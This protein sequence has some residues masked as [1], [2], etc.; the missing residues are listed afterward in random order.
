LAAPAPQGEVIVPE[1]YRA[2]AIDH[3]CE[4]LMLGGQLRDICADE[5]MPSMRVVTR[6]LNA[7][8]GFKKRFLEA[9][10][11]RVLVE[12]GN[13]LAIADGT[14]GGQVLLREVEAIDGTVVRHYDAADTARDKLR[15]DTR[16]KLLAKLEPAVF[17]DK[18]THGHEVTGELAVMLHAAMNQ[19]HRLP[20]PRND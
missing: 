10:R 8:A 19:G 5:T 18:V 14:D 12:S 4:Q 7:D 3:L 6:W 15:I 20:T 2:D 16:L 1:Q 17:G 9:Q 11:V 13:L